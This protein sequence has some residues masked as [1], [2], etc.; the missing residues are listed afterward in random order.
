MSPQYLV[1]C[2]KDGQNGC[3][4]GDTLAAYNFIHIKGIDGLNCTKYTEKDEVCPSKCEDGSAI[5]STKLFFGSEHYSLLKG[6]TEETVKAIQRDLYENGPLSMSF[7]VYKDFMT[8]FKAN[9]KGIYNTTGKGVLGGHA[10]RLVGWG[11]DQESGM[12]YWTI[13]NSWGTAFAHDGYFKVKRGVNLATFESRRVSAGKPKVDGESKT[14]VELYDYEPVIDGA[15]TKIAVN[16]EIIEIAKYSLAQMHRKRMPNAPKE[17]YGVEEAYTQVTNGITYHL[18]LSTG[19]NEDAAP[20]STSVVI[21][22][23][24]HNNL[25]LK[26]H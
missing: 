9:P 4:G 24:V 20:A 3:R 10:V 1:S 25:V 5:D 22:Q 17:F 11:K 7:V 21:H 26:S 8:F 19:A 16:E 14:K 23:D 13:A 2:D 6:T 15:P 18:T 12:E